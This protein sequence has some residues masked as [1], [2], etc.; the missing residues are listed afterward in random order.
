MVAKGQGNMLHI[1]VGVLVV[2]TLAL[3]LFVLQTTT[4]TEQID[5]FTRRQ[6]AFMA[7][8]H[9]TNLVDSTYVTD[10]NTY[11]PMHTAISRLCDFDQMDTKTWMDNEHAKE[12]IESYLNETIE[13][14][15]RL[16]MEEGHCPEFERGNMTDQR[17]S[18]S[19]DVMV[20]IP[21]PEKTEIK[22]TLPLE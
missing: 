7:E 17:I 16:E 22:L 9:L 11:I 19:R 5:T 18:R 12:Y 3:F 6:Q 21:Q 2:S 1:I 20:N 13:T 14:S 4:T 8:I 10:D 15:Y